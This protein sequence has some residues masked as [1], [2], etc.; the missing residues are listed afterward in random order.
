MSLTLAF[1]N[2]LPLPFLDGSEIVSTLIRSILDSYD[3]STLPTTTTTTV[4]TAEP[5][6][7]ATSIES[8][9]RTRMGKVVARKIRGG[10]IEK[11]LEKWTIAVGTGLILV[12]VVV[13][14][15]ERFQ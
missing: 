15:L 3:A 13:V 9:A 10:R 6:W 7:L 2:L 5:G 14:L 4:T 8:F 12:T 1:F 11:G